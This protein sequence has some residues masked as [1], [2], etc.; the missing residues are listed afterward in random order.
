MSAAPKS[1]LM[2]FKVKRFLRLLFSFFSS[3]LRTRLI[4]DQSSKFLLALLE[5]HCWQGL[6]QWV[7]PKFKDIQVAGFK[8]LQVHY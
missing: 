8:E 5:S 4:Y 3:S 1:F 6:G 2:T 7:S